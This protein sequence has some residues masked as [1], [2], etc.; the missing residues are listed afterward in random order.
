MGTACF[1]MADL[2]RQLTISK[3]FYLSPL[4]CALALSSVE[5]SLTWLPFQSGPVDELNVHHM[6]THR[7]CTDRLPLS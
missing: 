2:N 1:F 6:A 4:K 3:Y 5:S 7:F